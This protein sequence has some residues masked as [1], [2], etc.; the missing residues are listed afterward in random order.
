MLAFLAHKYVQSS[1]SLNKPVYVIFDDSHVDPAEPIDLLNVAFENPRKIL[2][3]VEGNI[4]G[5]PKRE[6]K[7]K[8][9]DRLDYAT[10]DVSYDVPDRLTGRQEVEE[11]RRLCPG[12][13]WNFVRDFEWHH[14]YLN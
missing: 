12:R 10:I 7:A 2:V 13:T 14:S 3:K 8:M 1:F 4:G 11:L 9:K 5:L 6:K